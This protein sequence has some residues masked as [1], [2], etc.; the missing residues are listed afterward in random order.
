MMMWMW[1]SQRLS[2]SHW[3][4]LQFLESHRLLDHHHRLHHPLVESSLNEYVSQHHQQYKDNHRIPSTITF[5][6]PIFFGIRCQPF[7]TLSEVKEFLEIHFV[8]TEARVM[9]Q[10]FL[11]NAYPNC[12]TH[13]M[14]RNIVSMGNQ[15]GSPALSNIA[16]LNGSRCASVLGRSSN[17]LLPRHYP[18]Q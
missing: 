12:R 8:E 3:N 5:I 11:F 7:A 10:S 1:E 14:E 13:Q 4:R 6:A 2:G 9:G 16:P 18:S 15:T 17:H